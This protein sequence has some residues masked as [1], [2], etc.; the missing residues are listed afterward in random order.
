MMAKAEGTRGRKLLEGEKERKVY[1]KWVPFNMQV[2]EVEGLS[3]HAD[4]EELLGWMDR[5]ANAP[6]RIFI[7]HGEKD[8]AIALQRGIKE[9]YGW[10]A[11]IPQLYQI[12]EIA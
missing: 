9:T 10:E 4:H 3:A 12:E 8:G 5:M 2:C 1:G 11:E 7:V 6:E